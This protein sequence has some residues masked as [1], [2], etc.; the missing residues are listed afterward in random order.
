MV[1]DIP[2]FGV[3]NDAQP[4]KTRACAYVVVANSEGLV[5]AVRENSG[6][7]LLPGGGI[8][9][10]ETAA[11]AIHREVREELGCTV[12]LGRCLGHALQFLENEGHSQATYAAFYEGHLGEECHTSP[13]FELQWV[14]PQEL[15]L[16]H[17]M[18]VAKALLNTRT[19]VGSRQ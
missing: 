14:P 7:L 9:P 17:Q 2:V 16:A 15:S 8:E 1:S 6:K 3:R 5:A 12:R 11:E 19:S 4:Q 10:S 18:W 13:E